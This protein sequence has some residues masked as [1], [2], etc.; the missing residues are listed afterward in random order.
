MGSSDMRIV[1]D[2][3]P[4]DPDSGGNGNLRLNLQAK[5]AIANRS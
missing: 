2:G 5:R 4:E 3:N 1:V